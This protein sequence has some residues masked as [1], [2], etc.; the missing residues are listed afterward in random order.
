[1]ESNVLLYWFP[2]IVLWRWN[3][4]CKNER[5]EQHA[6]LSFEQKNQYIRD[7]ISRWTASEK[8]VQYLCWIVTPFIAQSTREGKTGLWTSS[9]GQYRVHLDASRK[10]SSTISGC[11]VNFW[12]S[13]QHSLTYEINKS[14]LPESKLTYNQYTSIFVRTLIVCPK[15]TPIMLPR[16]AEQDGSLEKTCDSWNIQFNSEHICMLAET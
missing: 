8:L 15:S 16:S 13:I 1:M 3:R 14:K 5:I 9:W 10:Q 6:S 12:K 7:R 4:F 2:P 11:A